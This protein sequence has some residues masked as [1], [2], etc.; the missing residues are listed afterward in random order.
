VVKSSL[1]FCKSPTQ[2][3][4]NRSVRQMKTRLF[5]RI[6]SKLV[7]WALPCVD[8]HNFKEYCNDYSI[9]IAG[10]HTNTTLECHYKGNKKSSRLD[11]I[12]P[13]YLMAYNNAFLIG[14]HGLLFTSNGR[15]ICEPIIR[16]ERIV[17]EKTLR[18]LGLFRFICIYFM[19]RF[20]LCSGLSVR[21][22]KDMLYWLPRICDDDGRPHYGHW[23]GEHLPQIRFILQ[24]MCS[25]CTILVNSSPPIW[26][27][28]AFSIFGISDRPMVYVPT[29]KP[30]MR[31]NKIFVM[32]V[33]NV[34]SEA[35]EYDPIFRRWPRDFVAKS[36]PVK[37]EI[38]GKKY[39]IPRQKEASR[40]IENYEE[41]SALLRSHG[42]VEHDT[43]NYNLLEE[44]DIFREATE[45]IGP[46]GSNLIKIMFAPNAACLVEISTPET[47]D[48]PVWE[49]M[50]AELGIKFQC[51]RARQ[52]L[53]TLARNWY[54]DV[55]AL[56]KHLKGE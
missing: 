55:I 29:D 9:A 52:E 13:S 3:L 42:F 30:S 5:Y 51:V 38:E 35:Y 17:L 21:H 49:L 43:Q 26:Q 25:D 47:M 28:N 34:H 36:S 1:L 33:K 7:W 53:E 37:R 31:F 12:A 16:R 39:F 19:M 27:Q 45:I 46:F 54:V 40:V 24:F 50:C 18:G 11:R 32:T 41:V 2:V 44:I 4:T 8:R 10:Y 15:L 56:E 23:I 22:D 48:K 20:N 14:H 6:F